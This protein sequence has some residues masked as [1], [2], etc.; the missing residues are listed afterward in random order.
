MRTTVNAGDDEHAA[1][2]RYLLAA[3]QGRL[4]VFALPEEGE[5]VIGR[6][7]GC[8]VVLE[9]DKVSRQHARIRL[10][11]RITVADLGSRNGTIYR[12]HRLAV[13]EEREVAPGESFVVGPFSCL[14]LPAGAAAPIAGGGGSSLRVD[15]PTAATSSALLTAVARAPFSVLIRGETG[16]GKEVL[17]HTLHRLSGRKGPFVAVNCAAIAENLLESELFGHEKGAFTGA[18][19]KAGLLESAAGGTVLLD[20]VGEMSASLQAKLLRAIEEREVLR[21]GAVRPVAIDVRF[22]AATHR[23][24]LAGAR[25]RQDLYYRLAAVTL[26]IPPL[27]ERRTVIGALAVELLGVAAAR[28][29][30]PPPPLSAAAAAKLTG[31]AWAGNVRELRNVMD[32]ALLLAAGGE[33][34]PEHV[35]FDAAAAPPPE[36]AELEGGD[37]RAR[38]LAA[39][40]SCAGN[41]TRAAKLLG[42]SR[43]TLVTKLSIH[44]IPRP[45]K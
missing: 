28:Q 43:A 44:R 14:F 25:F 23:D 45:R 19:G 27:R 20:E 40:E 37:E 38:I 26:E 41:Q 16:V 18:V 31:H 2:P 35:T 9:H 1:G 17:A 42:I 13:D 3:A 7:E 5:V 8:G 10:G 34:A 36:D 32:R 6:A 30:L 24:L 21:V 4:R 29:G 15:D 33:I 39:L 11:A 22:L 12:G